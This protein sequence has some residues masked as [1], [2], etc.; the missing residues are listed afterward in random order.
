MGYVA[1]GSDRGAAQETNPDDRFRASQLAFVWSGPSRTQLGSSG[2]IRAKSPR[3][4]GNALAVR[5]ERLQPRDRRGVEGHRA[6]P[7]TTTDN[8]VSGSARLGTIRESASTYEEVGD[9]GIEPGWP[10]ISGI[11]DYLG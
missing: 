8:E 1:E 9:R 5:S 6:A 7:W 2:A 10:A 3:L 4:V 11:S